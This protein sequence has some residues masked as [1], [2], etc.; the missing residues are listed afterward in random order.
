MQTMALL[1]FKGPEAWNASSEA[2]V[3]MLAG[4]SVESIFHVMHSFGDID[5]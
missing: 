2:S 4:F 1:A 3:F 5:Q